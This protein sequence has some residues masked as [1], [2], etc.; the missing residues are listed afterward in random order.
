MT[1]ALTPGDMLAQIHSSGLLMGMTATFRR[2]AGVLRFDPPQGSCHVDVSFDVKSLQF[3]NG[4]IRSQALSPG[5]LDP[6][7]YPAMRYIGD[8]ASGRLVGTLTMHGQSHAFDMA[9]TEVFNGGALTGLHIA[10]KLDRYDW[11]LTGLTMTLAK[12]VSISEDI[13]LDG[14]LEPP[15]P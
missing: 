6:A 7:L 8:C 1:L 9:L 3:P 13:S 15:K 12:V 4:L 10:G 2:L 14:R 5:F 11:G